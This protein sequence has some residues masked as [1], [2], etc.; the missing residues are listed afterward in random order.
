MTDRFTE[1]SGIQ[2]I[3]ESNRDSMNV[4]RIRVA[5]GGPP[6]VALIPR[7]GVLAEYA[8]NG[9]LKPLVNA[10][11]SAGLIDSA[12]LTANYAQGIIDLGSV[13]GTVYAVLAK[14]NSKSTVWYK[15]SS[16]ADLG[17]G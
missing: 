11:G 4:L 9:D 2:V 10:D 17:G 3:I 14:A 8:R 1:V 5:S 13:D 12:L 15:P 16:F 7:P 6:D